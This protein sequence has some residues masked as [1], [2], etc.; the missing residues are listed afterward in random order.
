MKKDLRIFLFL[1]ILTSCGNK[2]D[3]RP[4]YDNFKNDWER[5]NLNGKI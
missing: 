4:K 1:L 3:Y 5:D 2:I